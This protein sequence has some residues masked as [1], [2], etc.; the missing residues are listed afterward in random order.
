MTTCIEA[1]IGAGDACLGERDTALLARCIR[2]NLDCAGLRV[3]T[4]E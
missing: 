2:L 3:A 1:S 4:G